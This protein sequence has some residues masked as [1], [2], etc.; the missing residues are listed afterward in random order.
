MKKSLKIQTNPKK[1]L[2]K[3]YFQIINFFFMLS[4]I[5]SQFKK[6]ISSYT[7][8]KALKK[9]KILP[10]LCQSIFILILIQMSYIIWSRIILVPLLSVHINQS[11]FQSKKKNLKNPFCVQCTY[12]SMLVCFFFILVYKANNIKFRQF[13]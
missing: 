1:L 13:S 10:N 3:K 12:V 7:K 2:K 9:K 6:F 8:T 5:Q 4:K 11:M